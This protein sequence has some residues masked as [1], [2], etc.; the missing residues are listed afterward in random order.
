MKV[1]R[2]IVA[3]KEA[4]GFEKKIV[5]QSISFPVVVDVNF[6]MELIKLRITVHNINFKKDPIK[7][8]QKKWLTNLLTSQS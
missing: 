3:I 1:V 4:D 7:T 6:E 8:V 2:C 5:I